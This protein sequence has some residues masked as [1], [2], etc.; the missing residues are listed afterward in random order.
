MS[1]VLVVVLAVIVC[2]AWVVYAYLVFVYL[3]RVRRSDPKRYARYQAMS[4][5]KKK[6]RKAGL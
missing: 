2:S 3:R 5:A 4:G 1:G 6:K